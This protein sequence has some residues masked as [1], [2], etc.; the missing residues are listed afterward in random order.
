MVVQA[1]ADDPV[2]AVTAD[3]VVEENGE[4][5]ARQKVEGL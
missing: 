1:I 5:N 3:D 2:L 4:N